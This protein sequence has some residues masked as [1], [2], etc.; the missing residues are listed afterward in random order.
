VHRHWGVRGEHGCCENRKRP[1]TA[2]F[3]VSW[4]GACSSQTQKFKNRAHGHKIAQGRRC[5]MQSTSSEDPKRAC[6]T[7]WSATTLQRCTAQL[8]LFS[9][10]PCASAAEFCAEEAGGTPDVWA[11]RLRVR[12]ASLRRMRSFAGCRVQLQGMRLLPIVPRP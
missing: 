10:E 12:A 9:G 1:A 7:R 8:S 4:P 3:G 6:S 5:H 11:A 2:N